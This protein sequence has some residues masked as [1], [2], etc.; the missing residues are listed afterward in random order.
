MSKQKATFELL[1][2]IWQFS[3]WRELFIYAY[4]AAFLFSCHPVLRLYL[5]PLLFLILILNSAAHPQL[6]GQDK[7]PC[8]LK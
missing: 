5:F 6:F 1:L 8:K 4:V 7:Q 2:W 3:V